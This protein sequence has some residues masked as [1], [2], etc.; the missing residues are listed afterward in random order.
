MFLFKNKNKKI[1]EKIFIS[2]KAY[3]RFELDTDVSF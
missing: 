2:P 1:Q 3:N